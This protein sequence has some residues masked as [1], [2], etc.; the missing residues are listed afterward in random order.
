ML[1]TTSGLRIAPLN[2]INSQVP[3]SAKLVTNRT[4]LNPGLKQIAAGVMQDFR[5]ELL[6]GLTSTLRK[7]LNCALPEKE[8]YG[9]KQN[10]LFGTS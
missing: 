7:C 5:G 3:F 1:N 4:I 6:G 10:F 9:M 2:G 8:T